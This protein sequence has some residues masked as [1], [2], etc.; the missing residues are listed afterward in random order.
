MKDI[1]NFTKIFLAVKPVDFRKQT[2]GLAA[3]VQ[4]ALGEA[5]SE[6]RS[7]FIFTN[8]RKTS[9]RILYWDLTGFALWTK[10][11]EKDRFKWPRKS[12][13]AKRL[14]SQRE[15]KWLLQGVDIE[16][17]KVHEPIKNSGVV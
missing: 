16:K 1:G 4:D 7:L 10:I 6:A 11:L 3:L 14:I 17:I 8:K 15:L 5:A 12:E 13:D 9:V 2:Y